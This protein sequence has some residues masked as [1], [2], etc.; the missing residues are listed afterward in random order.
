[1][2][3]GKSIV[4]DGKMGMRKFWSVA[5]PFG[6]VACAVKVS[7][8]SLI[9]VNVKGWNYA[10]FSQSNNQTQRNTSVP[11]PRAGIRGGEGALR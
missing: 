7:R 10:Y 4:L 2:K 1:M 5:L 8:N 11:L 9:K 6:K 3:V